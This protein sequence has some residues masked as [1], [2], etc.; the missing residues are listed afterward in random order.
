[1]AEGRVQWHQ[2]AVDQLLRSS[3]GPVGR[4]VARRASLIV[5]RA[6]V[7][8][9][10][11]PGPRVDTGNLRASLTYVMSSDSRGPM[12]L[13]GTNVVYAR[14]LEFGLRNGATYPFWGPAYD[15]ARSTGLIH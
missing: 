12:A 4:E 11:R 3:G 8:A 5:D 2:A 1:M 7:N 10:G 14:P 15:W 6:K 13:L 9:S